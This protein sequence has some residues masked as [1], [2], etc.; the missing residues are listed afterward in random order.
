M[1]EHDTI[2]FIGKDW[3]GAKEE[4]EAKEACIQKSAWPPWHNWI[5]LLNIVT[6]R[7]EN[8]TT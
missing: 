1:V 7:L 8:F 6:G 5:H 2:D 4:N 3:Q